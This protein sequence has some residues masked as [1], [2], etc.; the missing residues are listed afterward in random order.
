MKLLSMMILRPVASTLLAI[1]IVLLGVLAYF[2][3]PVAALPQADIPTI[4]V[5]A[6]LPGASPESM[7]A[8]VATPL[9]RA[10][11]GVSGVKAIN[12][13]SSQNSTDVVL[14][15]DLKTDINEAARE[16]Q[17]AIN[18]AMSQLP[19]G[20]PSPPDYFKVNPSQRPIF[21]LALSS[22]N[23]SAGQLYKI[24]ST[25]VQP[26]LAQVSGVGEVKIDGASMPAVRI[27]LHPNALISQG[28][29]LEQVRKAVV[30]SN[31]VQAL[32]VVEQ[33]QLRWQVSLAT[34]LNQ[35]QDFA[36][37][38][39]HQK[40][41]QV[42]RLKDVAEVE[43]SVENR[44]VSGYHNG[45]AAVILK[46]S[47]QPNANT[48]ATID[49]IK[50]RLPQLKTLLPA[51]SDLTIVMDG[52]E[53]IRASLVDAAETL[54]FSACFVVLIVAMLLGR[55]KSAWVPSLALAVTLI[56][57]CSLIYL[58]GFSLNNLSVMA[59][60]VAIGLVVDDAIVVL[61]NIQRHIELGL[62]PINAA[63]KG[64]QEVG[65]TLIAMNVVLVVIFGSVLFMGGVIE[66]LFKEFSLTLVFIVIL[67]VLVSLLFSPSLAA[68]V[69]QAQSHETPSR[70]YRS[71]QALMQRLTQAYLSSL[72]WLLRRHYLVLGFWL[73]AIIGSVYLYQTLPK[74][75]L[76]EQDT[77]RVESFIR[78]D[79]GF[80]FQVMQ[81]KIASFS[82]YLLSDPA[83]KD[84]IGISGGSGGFSNSDVMVSLK[85]KSERG[86]LSSQQIVERLKRDAPWHA[87]A[88]FSARVGQDLQLDDPFASGNAQEYMLLLQSDDLKLLKTWLP[89]V[90][91]AM[92]K[93]PELEEVDSVGDEGAQHVRLEID[94]E[95]AKR[96]GVDIS[97]VASVLNNAFSQRQISTIYD[98]TDQFY[99]VMEVDRHF[100]EHPESL[101]Q[102][103]VPN[104]Q[105]QFVPLTQ[106][107]SWSYGLSSDRV[108]RRNQFAVM[109]IGYV[110]KDGYR[111]EQ[112]DAAIRALMP[113]IMLPNNIFLTTDQDAKSQSMQGKLSMPMLILMVIVLIYLLLGI[114]YES[115]WHPL[116]ILSTVPAVALGALFCLWLF[117]IPFSLITLLGMFLLIGIVVK[118]AILM[119][120][121]SLS[122]RRQGRSATAAILS[123]ARLRFRPILMTNTAALIGAVPLLLSWGQGSEFRQPLGL[124]IVGGLLLGQVLTLYTTPVLYL[125]LERISQWFKSLWM[126]S[127]FFKS[128]AL[129]RNT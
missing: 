82:Q 40:E 96:Y 77:G 75:I 64:I 12:S 53:V 50:Q 102:V 114:C 109:G 4:V 15:F 120:D 89:K 39:I 7:S 123:A 129:D 34:D 37:L 93:L 33:Q 91:L 106:F 18:A 65:A 99:V 67:S 55:W 2:R 35:A 115:V 19:A 13:S 44:Y 49:Q 20:M 14:H 86:G 84:V 73:A 45:K 97:A 1:A 31:V 98:R 94:R 54:V 26:N 124:V 36:D 87:G 116:M 76:P 74:R 16:V 41:G 95:A 52:S 29:S 51:D 25:L 79:D 122:L 23:L 24:A 121:F 46:I 71:S 63:Q 88:V 125:L 118:N 11:M 47:R 6:H 32:G 119:I 81:P 28:V 83:V 60:I 108:Y 92:E 110:V 107:A 85:P 48:V 117:D 112:A 62:S 27:T 59:I 127:L 111:Y 8:T 22:E 113:E 30:Q 72:M 38:V 66:R 128:K 5:R 70:M 3:L 10:M 105:G 61:E 100:T 126:K 42:V 103:K 56:G 80:S 69:L 9:E 58:S 21:Y 101:A 78:G 57:S 68:R 17:A 90:A 43:D 104:A